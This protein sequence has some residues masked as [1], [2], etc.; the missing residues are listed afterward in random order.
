M[1]IKK[2]GV[3]LSRLK[4]NDIELVR[5]ERN[6][7]AI[8]VWMHFRD[9]ITPEMQTAWF[10]SI[11]NIYN[12]YFLIAYEN[13]KVGLIHT[14]NQDFT[15]RTCEGGIFV[16]DQKLWGTGLSVLCSVMMTDFA[17]YI[18]RF[19]TIYAK[20]LRNNRAAQ[21]YNRSLGYVP[22][23]DI[24]SDEEI[25]WLELNEPA[26]AQRME[27]IRSA[28]GTVSGDSSRLSVANI[29][30]I[31]DTAQEID[32]QRQGLPDDILDTLGPAVADSGKQ[33]G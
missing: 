16:W 11:N 7:V 29:D 4:K 31:D 17:F 33:S 3:T 26:Y 25:V 2:Y 5:V 23:R 8:K 20:V 12:S 24:V 10:E 22:T 1:R 9:V 30:Y 14:K 28:I 13:Q 15:Q 18:M 6:S 27:R 19:R 32:Q 21:R